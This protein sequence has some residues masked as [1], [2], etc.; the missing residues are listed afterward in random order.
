MTRQ[1]LLFWSLFAP[2]APQALWVR[3]TAARFPAAD[4][5]PAGLAGEGDRTLR[6]LALGDSIVAGVGA[7]RLE[8]ALVGRA[9]ASLARITGARV[10]WKAEGRSG[11]TSRQIAR[12][13]LPRV[14]DD[15]DRSPFDA[16]LVSAGVNDVISLHGI[17]RWRNDLDDLLKMLSNR[18]PGAVIAFSGLPPMNHFPALPQPLRAVFG[19]R[20]RQFDAVLH[21]R[22]NA[23]ENVI[24]IPLEFEANAESFSADGFHPS[25]ES[26]SEFGRV[27]AQVIDEALENRTGLDTPARVA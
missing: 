13:L 10:V 19:L 24:H 15:A 4:G 8:N 21:E 14:V 6:M 11:V 9:A 25:E 20:A 22:S 17:E 23:F 12:R 1:D 5:E 2:L 3:R 27:A 7:R 16:I 26:Y 18:W